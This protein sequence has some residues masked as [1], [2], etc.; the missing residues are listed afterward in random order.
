MTSILLPAI[1]YNADYDLVQALSLVSQGR[2]PR[3][4]MYIIWKAFRTRGIC[5][6]F[7][8]CDADGFHADLQKSA[9]FYL[10]YLKQIAEP[11]DK[12]TSKADPFFD[13]VACNDLAAARE[14]AR[15]ARPTWNE[16]EEYEDD[17]LYVF[18]L[19]QCL[20]PEA[21]EADRRA[22]LD[23][24]EAVLDGEESTRLDVCRALMDRDVKAFDDA[25]GRRIDEHEETYREGRMAD[26]IAEEEWATE[27]LLFVEGLALVVLAKH[28]GITVQDNYLYIPSLARRET[29]LP[30]EPN[31]W[32]TP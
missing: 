5:A 25:L 32:R 17:F 27:G 6:L 22:V 24:F 11:A 19:M 20:H 26:Y 12:V 3:D 31:A 7:L 18:F 13:A 30:H 29:P 2:M 9:A 28:L 8:E 4:R 16:G 1:E 10:H 15:H 21:A 23:A 14:I